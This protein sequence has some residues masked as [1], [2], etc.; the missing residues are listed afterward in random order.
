VRVHLR[1]VGAR[2]G[3]PFVVAFFVL[4][5]AVGATDAF[6]T[7]DAVRMRV[8][9]ASVTAGGNVYVTA[10]VRPAGARCTG[11]L[12]H[13]STALKLKPK[14]AIGG[15]V[16]WKSKIPSTAAGGRWT[17]RVAC[18]HAGSAS[19]RFS[20]IA[21]PSPPP[22]TIPAKVVV[23]KS[24]V[25][26]RPSGSSY[27]FAGYGVVLQNVSPDEDALQVAVT[28]NILDASGLILHSESDTYT[29]IPAGAT[30]YAGGDSFFSGSTPA[31]RV[32][33]IVQVGSHQKKSIGG[34]P[35]VANIRTSEGFSSADVLGEFQNPYTKT[36]SSLARITA[37][38][39]DASGNVIGGGFDY[40]N[41]SV[42][43]GGRIG[44]D[45]SIQGLH[46]SQIASAQVSVEP[47]LTG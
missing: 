19:A 7:S 15:A 30:Y 28:V 17:A 38:C 41:S 27:T 5:L 9:P 12:S 3:R 25:S 45:I 42:T 1:L 33:A 32:E 31:A 16:S 13:G 24:G 37:V 18:A 39:F 40:P 29:A 14:K 4:A 11:A 46:A 23:V 35:P 36:I 22:P 8:A 26:S 21:R 20:V 6:G 43:P 10:G 44:F 34:L 47:E 2:R